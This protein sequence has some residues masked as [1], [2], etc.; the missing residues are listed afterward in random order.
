MDFSF[1]A[2]K[3]HCSILALDIYVTVCIGPADGS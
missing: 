2:L 1:S 3:Q